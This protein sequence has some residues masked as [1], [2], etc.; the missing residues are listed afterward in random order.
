MSR[1]ALRATQIVAQ[2]YPPKKANM[3]V[4]AIKNANS[5]FEVDRILLAARLETVT[6]NMPTKGNGWAK[7]Q[8]V[9]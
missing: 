7:R 2:L 9:K 1:Y 5:D 6:V 4:D 8:E 3:L